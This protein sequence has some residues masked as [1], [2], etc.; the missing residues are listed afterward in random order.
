[1]PDPS[2]GQPGRPSAARGVLTLLLKVVV[3]AGLLYLLLG[4]TDLSRLW[5]FARGAS[6]AWLAVA[7]LLY[8]AMLLLSV[9]RW[10]ILLDA[11]HVDVSP[12]RLLNSYLVATFFNNFLPSNIGGDVIRIRDTARQAGSKT[13]ATTVVLMDRGL[14]LL[15]LLAIAALGST[16]AGGI[17]GRPPVL[18]S[19]LWLALAAGLA[20]SA[21]AVLLPG[22]VA[23]L[24][25]PLR[26]IHQEWVGERIGRLTGA[27]T[28]FRNAPGALVACLIGA[29][30]VQAVLVAFYAAI[31]HSMNIP[32][33]A[34]HL[35][36]I[37]PISFVVQMAPVSLNGFGV[38]EATFSFYFSRIGLPIESALVVSFMGAGLI[39]LFS[40]SGAVAYLLR[41][42]RRAE[43]VAF[44]AAATTADERP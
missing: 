39:I 18:A 15:G 27:L 5:S 9:W 8:L 1:M 26:L 31:V 41:G 13:L 40:L 29:V 25:S 28:K 2:T 38:R 24:L 44:D 21:A 35:A 4:R 14:G 7:L 37:V 17:G 42:P 33:S 6:P 32:V 22:G 10:R 36:V 20:A 12:G 30:F 16:I 3:S 19:L 11:Q 43:I 23:R 34:W